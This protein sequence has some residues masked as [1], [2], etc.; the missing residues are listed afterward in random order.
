MVEIWD[1]HGRVPMFLSWSKNHFIIF[2]PLIASVVSRLIYVSCSLWEQGSAICSSERDRW[3]NQAFF[4]PAM[5]RAHDPHELWIIIWDPH[6]RVPMFV[7]C[8]KNQQCIS[9]LGITAAPSV[10]TLRD[11]WRWSRVI[12][13]SKGKEPSRLPLVRWHVIDPHT[14]PFFGQN[15]SSKM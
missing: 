7:L 3:R 1:P 9:P 6:G 14:D 10:R 12:W 5:A 2:F 13:C 15:P 8:S 11:P 4:S